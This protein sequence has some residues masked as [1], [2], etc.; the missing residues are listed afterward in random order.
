[1]SLEQLKEE[2]EQQLEEA[3]KAEVAEPEEPEII[4]KEEEITPEPEEKK[5]ELDAAGYAK[6]RREKAAEKK[7]ADELEAELLR[8][9]AEP[10]KEEVDSPEID[11]DLAEFKRE[12]LVSRAERE[13]QALESE[14][15]RTNPEYAPIAAEY[16]KALQ[17]SFKL[18]N[19]SLSE[20]QIMEKTKLHILEKASD[21]MNKGYNPVEEL[22]HEAK[23]LGFKGIRSEEKEEKLAPDMKKVA[24][25]RKKSAGMT[26]SS[27]K[28][29]GIL[30][31][32]AAAE[33]TSAEWMRLSKSERQ[34]LM[35]S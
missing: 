32:E 17:T 8:L 9:K 12:R 6:L 5:E 13:F 28:T 2:L 7:R 1:M 27:G 31:K 10:Q 11:P 23:E 33:L 14:Y 35:Y 19:K 3:K 15:L 4:E 26:A 30:T 29:E 20:A 21:Y 16:A 34:R 24:E 22:F 25:N 18:Q